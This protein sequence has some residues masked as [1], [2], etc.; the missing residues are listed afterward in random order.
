M[1]QFWETFRLKREILI[2]GG[3]RETRVAILEDDRLVTVWAARGAPH[4]H[5]R[6]ELSALVE[7]LWPLTDADASARI[8]S[9]QIPDGVRLGIRAFRVTAE[10]FR[11]VV[12]APM[13]RGEASTEVTRRVPAELTYDCRGCK[14]RHI[15]GNV[16]QAL[17][18]VSALKIIVSPTKAARPFMSTLSGQRGEGSISS[19]PPFEA[20]FICTSPSP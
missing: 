13:P 3:P 12:T 5:R 10:A 15:A 11:E 7:R 16:W 14:A 19:T 6:S 4:L 18:A 1:T 9:G 2:N 20:T 8:N 17:P